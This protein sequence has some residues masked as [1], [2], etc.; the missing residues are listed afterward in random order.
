MGVLSSFDKDQYS[1]Q[2]KSHYQEAVGERDQFGQTMCK[3]VLELVVKSSSVT[4]NKASVV[5]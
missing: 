2:R 3:Q 1:F 4:V 5:L